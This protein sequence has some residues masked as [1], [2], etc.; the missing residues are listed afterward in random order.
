MRG[1]RGLTLALL[2]PFAAFAQGNAPLEYHG[3]AR[4]ISLDSALALARGQNGEELVCIGLETE[5]QFC[6]SP[7]GKGGV[8]AYFSPSPRH[9]EEVSLLIPLDARTSKD[10]IEDWFEENWGLAAREGKTTVSNGQKLPLRSE[11]LGLWVR[12]GL[13]GSASIVSLGDHR[14]LGV[15]IMSPGRTIRRLREHEKI[16]E[17]PVRKSAR[18]S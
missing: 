2:F 18:K 13:I 7:F 14:T 9:L 12:P 16:P 6:N 15:T 8:S 17:K 10:S 1:I 3:W 4:G 5:T 11:G